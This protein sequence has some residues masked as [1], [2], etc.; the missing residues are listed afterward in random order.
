MDHSESQRLIGMSKR[1]LIGGLAVMLTVLV[2]LPC[3]TP[4][5]PASAFQTDPRLEDPAA[6]FTDLGPRGVAWLQLATAA[7]AGVGLLVGGGAGGGWSR[8]SLG[9]AA[10]GMA[11][12]AWHMNKSGARWE[13]WTQGGAWVCAA[14]AGLTGLHLAQHEIARRWVVALLAAAAVPLLAGAAW[15]VW[16][17]H[18]D[19][20]R[21]F[22]AYQNDI[23]AR[24][25]IAP[26]SEAAVLYER[27]LRFADATG[28]F[29]LS[30]VL[31]SVA[32]AMGLLG[33]GIAMG[34]RRWGGIGV[35][36]V[37][38]AAGL[39]TVGLTGSKGAVVAVA[40][41]L[42]MAALVWAVNRGPRS[43]NWGKWIPAV[44]VCL[45]ALAFAAVLVRGAMGPPAPPTN[46]FVAGA[47][48]MGERSLLFRYQYWTAAAK[49]AAE[50]PILGSGAAGFADAYPAAKVPLNPETVTSTHNVLIDQVTML[51]IGGAAWSALLVMWLWLS[52]KPPEVKAGPRVE[53]GTDS[54]VG[55]TRPA[56][57]TAVAAAVL[58]FG[59]TL[60][61]RQSSL[62]L[63]S[64]LLWLAAIA[65][66]IGVAATLGSPGMVSPRSQS[67]GLLLAAVVVMVH[68]QVEMAFFQPT[69]MG[70]LWLIVGAAAGAGLMG[71]SHARAD[72]KAS[73][74]RRRWA[75][76]VAATILS[77]FVLLVMGR[78]VA[79]VHRHEV[80][81]D[82]ARA[83]LLRGDL[84]ST[85]QHLAEGQDAAGKDLDALR[86][87]VQL[88]AMEPLFYLIEHG[89]KPE[90][91]ERIERAIA[92]VDQAGVESD[93]GPGGFQTP[94][95]ARLRAALAGQLAERWRT[96][97]DFAAAEAAYSTL[98]AGSPYNISDALA[99]A[100]L[101]RNAGDESSA[102]ER[103]RSVLRLRE[104]KYLDAA[105]PLTPGQLQRVRAFVDAAESP[106]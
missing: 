101:A 87:R 85:L 74:T 53:T 57:W 19:S 39:F 50:H 32:A 66:F 99:R 65:G 78:Q 93:A 14:M 96:P 106:G 60:T 29:G 40:A 71:E 6:R 58:L 68:N 86:W 37:V 59:V 55:V 33:V 73:S 17:E 51:G 27:R 7:V 56:V 46:G 80:A 92:W 105:D 30:N 97:A 24:Q 52:A 94:K 63:E 102:R 90:A 23:F 15:Y 2:L 41:G 76:L 18:P 26:G 22:E 81:L 64:A 16:V 84:N 5:T 42:G 95:I 43:A 11:A 61:V 36:L 44:A 100:E 8:A 91:R 79:G 12:A 67:L 31:A 48:I 45:V 83:S 72:A 77:G 9:L 69:S 4:T 35:G 98:F 82:G 89:R 28:T 103:Y 20:V 34:S 21:F 75:G 1:A 25:G 13:D 88:Y 62:Y 54:G 3:F 47:P 49:I 38:A 10:V 70:L 104:E